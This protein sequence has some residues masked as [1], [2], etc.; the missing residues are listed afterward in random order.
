[1]NGLVPEA[2]TVPV[3]GHRVSFRVHV[4]ANCRAAA[5]SVVGYWK[6]CGLKDVLITAL[7]GGLC[8]CASLEQCISEQFAVWLT[9]W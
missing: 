5:A 9:S 7:I 8:K 4:A 3:D 6:G 1:M 2:H